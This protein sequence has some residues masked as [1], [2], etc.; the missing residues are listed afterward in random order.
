M[1]NQTGWCVGKVK[2]DLVCHFW[3]DNSA[4]YKNVEQ[5]ET[6]TDLMSDQA[7]T[8]KSFKETEIF[9]W[10]FQL[11]QPGKAPPQLQSD[12]LNNFV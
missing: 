2:K 1:W 7:T 11:F 3:T 10:K 4:T 6:K 9:G 12:P 5:K 8:S